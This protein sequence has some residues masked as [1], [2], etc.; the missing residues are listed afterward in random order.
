MNS[1]LNQ[2][3]WQKRYSDKNHPWDIGSVAPALKDYFDQLSNKQL[4]IL[5]PGCGFA[6]EAKYLAEE[7]FSN[8][9]C[10]DLV[11]EVF[12]ESGLNKTS[13]TCLAIDFFDHNEQYDLIIEQTFF[14]A[15]DPSLRKNYAAQVSTNLKENGKLVGLLFNME[16]PDGPPFGG[17]E[18]EYRALFSSYFELRK[19][20]P[21]RNSVS[22]R[23]EFFINF[24]KKA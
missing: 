18:A 21:C 6:H 15:L 20:E 24:E 9:T 23:S 16:K 22:A 5:I 3:Y 12:E 10:I 7:G 2:N 17:S 4:K 14:C 19:L 13:V 8:V 1:S 11:D